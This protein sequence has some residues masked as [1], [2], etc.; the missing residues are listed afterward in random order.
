MEKKIR[1]SKRQKATEIAKVSWRYLIDTE[2]Y[3]ALLKFE[4]KSFTEPQILC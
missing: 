3:L 2:M 4:Q 1:L